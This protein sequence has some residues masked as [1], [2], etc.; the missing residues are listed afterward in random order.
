MDVRFWGTRGSIASPGLQTTRYGGNTPCVEV[1]AD[2]GTLIVLDCGTGIRSLGLHLLGTVPRPMRIHLFIGH[3]HWDHIQ[4]FPF[5][6]P[7]FLPDTELNIYAPAGFQRSLED[8]LAGQMQYS[9]FPVKLRDLRSR[10][11]FTELEEGF[12]RVGE[13]FVETQYLNHT[14]PNFA[15]RIVSGAATLAYAADHEPFWKSAGAAFHHPGDQH[16]IAFL[17]RADLVIHD[18]QYVEEEY[19]TRLGWGHSTIEYATDVAL[20]AGAARLALF[21]HDPSRD[22]AAV[23]SLEARARAR[24]AARGGTLEVFAAAEGQ[25]IELH[26]NGH[27]SA[28]VALSALKSRPI[29][30]RRV[31]L[32]SADEGQASA[33][34][35]A[36][37][38]D[39]L[40]LLNLLGQ[41]AALH[42]VRDLAPDL[43]IVDAQLSDGDGAALIRPLRSRLERPDLPVL[44]LTG[45]PDAAAALR[46]ADAGATDCLARP[47]SA[48]TLRTRVRA[49]LARSSVAAGVSADRSAQPAGS[50]PDHS[51][52]DADARKDQT[53]AIAQRVNILASVP[54]FRPLG[55][56]QLEFLA[57]RATEQVY[58]AGQSVIQ[59]NDPADSLLVVLSGRVRITEAT[60]DI[61]QVGLIL[62]ELGQGEI[63]GELGIL[64]DQP[65]T[66]TV[67]ATEPTHCLVLPRQEFLQVLQ[68]S[69]DLAI[70]LLRVLSRRLADA[71][72]LLARYAPDPVTGLASRRA[73]YDQYRA[74]AAGARRRRTSVLLLL[75]DVVNLK[76]INDRFGYAAGDEVLRTVADALKEVTRSTDLVARY[77]GDE[78]VVLLAD[79][80][81][82]VAELVAARVERRLSEIIPRRGLTAAVQCSIGMAFSLTPPDTVDTLL[83]EADQDMLRKKGEQPRPPDQADGRPTRTRRS[84]QVRA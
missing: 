58:Q 42:Q 8:A 41:R 15:Y 71:D 84:H 24:V 46:S 1:R 44:L 13:V 63:I 75:L 62:G 23:A 57:T 27:A 39:G 82:K 19:E 28:V 49:W 20:A 14:A 73:F 17:E 53:D 4:G 2:D 30:G 31:L 11:H 16:H 51:S 50:P 79:V 55:R 72:R 69:S 32:V 80:G 22:D 6:T 61:P 43:V 40:V 12:F 83:R 25:E 35:Q 37:A 45:T 21:H 70:A 7:A 64:S 29:A 60:P 3:T 5:F 67:V 74:L 68:G 78:F 54:L 34:G 66:A 59:Q 81:P 76:T 65:R 36:L 52:C 48:P 38:E 10:I 33:I 26:G 47:V 56:D 18:A 77:G 9:Y